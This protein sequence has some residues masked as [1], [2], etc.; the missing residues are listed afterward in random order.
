VHLADEK[1]AILDLAPRLFEAEVSQTD[2][3]DLGAGK[4]NAGFE[5]FLDEIFVVR[6][7][8]LRHD[9]DAGCSHAGTSFHPLFSY[10]ITSVKS[11]HAA[12]GTFRQFHKRACRFPRRM[13]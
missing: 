3:L 4:L 6:F 5:F 9:L 2:G 8:V 1:L 7:L 13:L 10:Y 12:S 11:S